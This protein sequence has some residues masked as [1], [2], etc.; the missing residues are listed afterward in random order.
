MIAKS[1]KYFEDRYGIK[2]SAKA[3]ISEE[4]INNY[5]LSEGIGNTQLITLKDSDVFEISK[6]R[7]LTNKGEGMVYTLDM[8]NMD[9]SYIN[10]V[11]SYI[12]CN[13]IKVKKG[14]AIH[15][16]GFSSRLLQIENTPENVNKFFEK[17]KLQKNTK[18]RTDMW[19]KVDEKECCYGQTIFNGK[20]IAVDVKNPPIFRVGKNTAIKIDFNDILS[21]ENKK[22]LKEGGVILMG[23]N[24]TSLEI[25]IPR[26]IMDKACRYYTFRKNDMSV[27]RLQGYLFVD[28]KGGLCYKECSV[29]GSIVQKRDG[30]LFDMQNQSGHRLALS[31]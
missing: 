15:K 23:R 13:G 29:N 5:G 22:F 2:I 27:S 4:V 17:C 28:K 6:W 31:R 14:Y 7:E 3:S 1:E 26:E 19:P 25:E 21:A 11:Y 10:D 18:K 9:P 8:P 24:P 16:D 30:N 12:I 20:V